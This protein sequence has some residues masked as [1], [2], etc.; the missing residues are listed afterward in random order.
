MFGHLLYRHRIFLPVDDEVVKFLPFSTNG[1]DMKPDK[2]LK[3]N[4]AST[5]REVSLLWY[6]QN[7]TLA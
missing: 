7:D 3:L 4:A 6:W 1:N 5:V 2:L